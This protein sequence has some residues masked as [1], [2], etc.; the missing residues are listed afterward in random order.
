MPTV[1]ITPRAAR[2]VHVQAE[3]SST[4]SLKQR[5]RSSEKPSTIG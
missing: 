5:P 2:I 1:K 4:I 3:T